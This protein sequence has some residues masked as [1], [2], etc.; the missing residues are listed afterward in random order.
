MV[1]M[2]ELPNQITPDS[3]FSNRRRGFKNSHD[4]VTIAS[5]RVF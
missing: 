4:I 2:N 1:I 5:R 3:F